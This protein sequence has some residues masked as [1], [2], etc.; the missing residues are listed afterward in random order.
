M[1][2]HQVKDKKNQWFPRV[3]KEISLNSLLNIKLEEDKKEVNQVVKFF[4]SSQEKV[5]KLG[6]VFNLAILVFDLLEFKIVIASNKV[7]V[8]QQ[9]LLLYTEV[10]INEE[11]PCLLVVWV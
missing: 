8:K 1:E 5:S 11:D 10:S 7:K 9:E 3:K 2:F 4:E 6:K